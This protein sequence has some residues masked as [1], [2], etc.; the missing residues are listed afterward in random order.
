MGLSVARFVTRWKIFSQSENAGSQSHFLDM[1]EML[2]QPHPA[3]S[4]SVG[5]R[6]AFEKHVSKTRGGKG[7]ADVWM[8]DHFAWEYKGKHK[9]LKKAYLFRD[10]GAPGARSSPGTFFAHM[11]RKQR[12]AYGAPM[13]FQSALTWVG[14]GR[15][16]RSRPLRLDLNAAAFPGQ[17]VPEA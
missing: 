11:S 16:Q 17:V 6:Y 3:A 13:F 7:F 1:C 15:P 2:G 14:L 10:A 9:D 4:D 8:R 12:G 5:E